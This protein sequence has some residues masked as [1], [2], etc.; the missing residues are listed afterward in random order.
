MVCRPFFNVATAVTTTH[1]RID[2]NMTK[3]SPSR[4]PWLFRILVCGIWLTQIM[5]PEVISSFHQNPWRF[6]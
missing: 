1:V 5:S 4:I 6:R 2:Q 3:I